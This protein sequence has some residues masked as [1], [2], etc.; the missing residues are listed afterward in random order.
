MAVCAHY[1]LRCWKVCDWRAR[2][3]PDLKSDNLSTGEIK[4]HSLDFRVSIGRLEDQT[5]A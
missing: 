4:K 2:Y 1:R 5:P 3:T